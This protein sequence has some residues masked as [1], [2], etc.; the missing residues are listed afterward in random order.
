MKSLFKNFRAKYTSLPLQVRASLWFFLCS[1]MQKG[2]SVVVTPIFTRLMSTTE[3]GQF[4]VFN[5]WLGIFT[6]FV[7]LHMYNAV[8]T[9][10]L[11]K[12]DKDKDVFSSSLQGLTLVLTC[13][14]TAVYLISSDFW[15]GITNLT[16]VQMLAM[17]WMIWAT[18]AFSFWAAEQRVNLSYR[19]LVLLTILVSICKPFLSI[20][21]VYN[22]TDKVTARIIGILIVELVGY[23]GLFFVQLK[24]GKKF[25]SKRFW[26]YSLLFCLPLV[27]H[28]LSQTVLNGADKIMIERMVG[29]SESGIYAL[30]YSLSQ[31]MLMINQ[32]L[33][34]TVNPWIYQK[35]KKKEV[36]DI[37]KVALPCLAI[38]GCLNILLICFA[39]EIVSIFAPESYY[40]AIWVIPP[41]ALSGYFIFAYTL[42]ADFEFYYEKKKFIAIATAVS[43][44][45]NIG[46]NYVFI[47]AFGYYAAGYTTLAC[48]MVY[49]F[50]HYFFMRK[51]LKEYHDGADVYKT[52]YL[53]TMTSVFLL[54]G[55]LMLF[56]YKLFVLRYL[57]IALLI[58]LI[59]IFRKKIKSIVKGIIG[60]RKKKM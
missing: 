17:I 35:I 5:T 36:S 13:I 56:T 40:D 22:S 4:N 33:V 32:A 28:Y 18:S 1:V 7:S 26:K 9:Q 54:V 25:Y 15:N 44:L 53:I 60:V 49:T 12:F 52:K 47:N 58:V 23:T 27:P 29:A 59:V 55:L 3:Y 14:W 41:V 16:L 10:G 38:I 48:Y 8:Y 30:A 6:V 19:K 31:L 42:F 50:G 11:V 2:I 51:I 34:Q 37:H 45:L 24:K 43:A 21:L 46:L 20:I 57:I 39:P